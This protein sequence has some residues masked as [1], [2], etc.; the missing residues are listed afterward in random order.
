MNDEELIIPGS[1]KSA[2]KWHRP[3]PASRARYPIIFSARR[4]I[5][6]KSSIGGGGA[7]AA[8]GPTR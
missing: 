8:R 6:A 7:S 3:F 2:G 4:R 5:F 1:W